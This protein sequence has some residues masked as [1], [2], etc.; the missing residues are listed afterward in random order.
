MKFLI[1]NY[2][3]STQSECM[4]I[5]TALNLLS[6]CKS[7]IWNEKTISAYDIFDLTNLSRPT[8]KT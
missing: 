2:S 4:Y 8:A 5:N 1:S 7:T 3:T 6:T